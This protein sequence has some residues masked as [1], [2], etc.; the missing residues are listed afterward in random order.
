MI[1]QAAAREMAEQFIARQDL[2]GHK[3]KFVGVKFNERRPSEWGVVFD[4]YT[5]QDSL[6][7]GPV[8]ILVDRT[9]G[10]T[11]VL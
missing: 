7:D 9:S 6:L 1:D 2:K 11:R 10:A 3:Y 8:V 4:V 5:L